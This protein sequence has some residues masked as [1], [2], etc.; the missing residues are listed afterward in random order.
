MNSTSSAA[1]R[2]PYAD[3]PFWP[4][5]VLQ[6]RWALGIALSIGLHFLGALSTTYGW[7]NLMPWFGKPEERPV[8]VLRARLA[9]PPAP[10]LAAAP[11]PAPAKPAAKP[12]P[13]RAGAARSAPAGTPVLAAAAR[14]AAQARF[15]LRVLA[16]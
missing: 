3:N 8:M 4:S 6:R 10:P 7:L 16:V 13:T 11:A 1:L 14:I 9:T 5:P 2:T 12:R 15:E